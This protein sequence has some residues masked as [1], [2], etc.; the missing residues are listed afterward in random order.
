MRTEVYFIR[1]CQPDY[2]NRDDARRALT[3]RGM[4]DRALVTAYLA[5]K[6]ISLVAS[7]PFLR[8]VDTVGQFA[9]ERGLEI[10]QIDDLREHK[11]ANAWVEDF[12][13]FSRRQWADFSYTLD[14]GEC[15]GEV[16]SRCI[17]AIRALLEDHPGARIAI[18]FHGT[19]LSTVLHYYDPTFGFDQ[20][21]DMSDRMPW[22]AHLTFEGSACV[23]I[24]STDLS[25]G[26]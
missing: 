12:E 6:D 10:L 7:S 23:H 3:E 17:A 19:A 4:A 25:Q 1:H 8:A 11:L 2:A 18:G 14:D 13:A 15:L 9:A 5:D 21:W 26:T 22:C 16:Q 24:E 20:F